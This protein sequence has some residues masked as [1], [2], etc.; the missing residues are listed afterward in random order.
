MQYKFTNTQFFNSSIPMFQV[1]SV[2]LPPI[3]NT[4]RI[5]RK[6]NLI[7]EILV[8]KDISLKAKESLVYISPFVYKDII[9][10]FSTSDFYRVRTSLGSL[11]F[12]KLNTDAFSLESCYF[13]QNQGRIITIAPT[14]LQNLVNKLSVLIKSSYFIKNTAEEA[15]IYISGNSNVTIQ[16]STFL[17]NYSLGRGSILFSEKKNSL[18][19]I[20]ASTFQRNYAINGG[21]MFTQIGGNITALNST[22]ED[23]F[24]FQGGVIYSQNDG[25]ALF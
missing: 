7:F 8:A 23:N 12:L 25:S 4:L 22:F 19:L 1:A 15:L 18:A 14:E 5:M 21:V 13:F 10:Q 24:A 17:D 3:N 6:I 20:L 11:F 16:S 2:L 9:I